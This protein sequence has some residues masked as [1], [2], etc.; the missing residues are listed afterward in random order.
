MLGA[1]FFKTDTKFIGTDKMVIFQPYC[2]EG[3]LSHSIN[4]L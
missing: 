1:F 3:Q 2:K 4:S